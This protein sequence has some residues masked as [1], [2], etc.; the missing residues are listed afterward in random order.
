M[1]S[2]PAVVDG[3]VYIGGTNRLAPPEISGRLY[4]F[5]LP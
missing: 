5:A 1:D 3:R 2:S 4:V